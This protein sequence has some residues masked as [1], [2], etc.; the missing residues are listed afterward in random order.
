MGQFQR[1]AEAPCQEIEAEN[2]IPQEQK[3]SFEEIH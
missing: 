1:S 3:M 2:N